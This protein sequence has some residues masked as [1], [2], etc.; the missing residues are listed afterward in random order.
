MIFNENGQFKGNVEFDHFR[1]A[2]LAQNKFSL[3]SMKS[4]QKKINKQNTSIQKKDKD[5]LDP[6]GPSVER[7]GSTVN[8]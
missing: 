4:T 1:N 8:E 3:F 7:S 2:L 5:K 6:D